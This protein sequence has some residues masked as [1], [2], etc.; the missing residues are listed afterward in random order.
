MRNYWRYL[1]YVWRY[2]WRALTSVAASLLGEA[3]NFA[4]VGALCVSVQLLLSLRVEGEPG[5]LAEHKIFQSRYGQWLLDYLARHASPQTSDSA[6]MAMMTAIGVLFLAVIVVRGV[7][8][9]LREYLLQSANERAWTDMF[10]DLFRRITLLSMRFHTRQS[11]GETMST[12]GADMNEL[13]KGGSVIFKHA[14][15]DPVRLALGLGLTLAISL[16]LSL[17]IYVALPLAIAIIKQVGDRARR[18]TKKMLKRRADSMKILGET[19]QGAAVIKAYDAEHYQIGRFHRSALRMRRYG[20]RR[21]LVKAL[22]DPV[23]EI[24]YWACRIAVMLYGVY[25]VL[26]TGLEVATLVF[27]IY[28][29]RQVYDPLSKLRRVFTSIQESTAAADR[30]FHF[31]DIEPEVVDKPDAVELPPHSKDIEFDHVSFAYTPPNEVVRDFSLRIQAGEVV[32]VV[33]ENGSGKS[34]VVSLLLRFYDP[35][36]GVVRIDGFDLRDVTLRSLRRQM[37]FVSQQVVL[38]NDT[39]RH[40]IAFGDTAYT[41]EEIEAAARAALAHDFISRL[42]DGYDTIVGEQ[43]TQLSGGQRQRIALA[44]ALLRRPRILVMDEATSA[45]DADAEDRLQRQLTQFATDRTV[46]VVAHRFSALRRV[47]RIVV[48]ADGRIERVGTHKEL[49]A[50]SPTYQNLYIKQSGEAD[51]G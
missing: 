3:L 51:E 34:T 8:D 14:V 36:R 5:S 28:C 10:N 20:L 45:L 6:F 22:A 7:L 13:R 11:L 44:R 50:S 32:A 9:F 29:V 15:R 1:A 37:G 35:T 43:G 23:T 19:V 46:I 16:R 18:Y 33:G 12:F 26:T 41:D 17:V 30:V 21:A 40:N 47:D 4:S 24:L 25:L 27:F 38:F 2:K 42:A 48:M 49:M 31:M 39:I